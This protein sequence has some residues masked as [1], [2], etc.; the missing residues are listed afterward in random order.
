MSKQ[1]VDPGNN[2]GLLHYLGVLFNALLPFFLYGA[3][4]AARR[5]HVAHC[6]H[7]SSQYLVAHRNHLS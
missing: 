3:G 1:V 6:S 4:V 7:L 2:V 5:F